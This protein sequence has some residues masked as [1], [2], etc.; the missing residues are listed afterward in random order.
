MNLEMKETHLLTQLNFFT[1]LWE[2]LDILRNKYLMELVN[3]I[4]I[5]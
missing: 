4:N 1:L 2:T 5:V 3:I